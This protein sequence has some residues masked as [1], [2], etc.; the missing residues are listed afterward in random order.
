[1]EKIRFETD[2]EFSVLQKLTKQVKNQSAELSEK[3]KVIE[4]LMG[5][6]AFYRDQNLKNKVPEFKD[7]LKKF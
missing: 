3:K 6:I 7:T 1:M 5:N 4:E 2:V